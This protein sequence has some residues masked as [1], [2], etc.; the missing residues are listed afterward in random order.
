MFFVNERLQVI[1]DKLSMPQDFAALPPEAGL[2]IRDALVANVGLIEV[3]VAENPAQLSEDE[4][5]IVRS[6][7][8]MVAGRFYAFRELA[9][10]T[11]FLSS[12]D[13]ANCLR[14]RGSVAALRRPAWSPAASHNRDGLAAVQRLQ[15]N[16]NAWA[17]G[18]AKLT[19]I[20]KLLK[21][22]P[23]DPAW[24]LPSRLDDNPLV[25]NIE[26]NG[27]IIDVRHAPRELQEVAFNK[28]LIPYIPADRQ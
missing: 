16:P 10:Y 8:H 18:K 12:S 23:L 15:G 6:W 24:S 3:F 25:W 28:G 14:R 21:V 26:V 22:Y 27:F 5:E 11:V 4:L 1:P 13:P 9:K 17:S 7:R 19:A 2:I 20:R